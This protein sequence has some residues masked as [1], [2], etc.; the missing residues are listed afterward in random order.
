MKN[1]D[2]G[3][4]ISYRLTLKLQT[5]ATESKQCSKQ[6]CLQIIALLNIKTNTSMKEW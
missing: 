5:K 3:V 4:L 6:I 1:Q 2:T